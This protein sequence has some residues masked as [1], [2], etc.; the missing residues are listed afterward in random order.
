VIGS[1]AGDKIVGNGL[2]NMIDG[3]GGNDQLTG[4][5]GDDTLVFAPGFGRDIVTD[6]DAD[7]ASG[8]DLLDISAFGITAADFA[9]RIAISDLGVHTLITIDGD[10]N[11]TIRLLGVDAAIVTQD[12]FVFLTVDVIE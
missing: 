6:F 5:G 2:N 3:S 1:Q 8:Q 9:A 12:D 10:P 4:G 7:S 11:Q